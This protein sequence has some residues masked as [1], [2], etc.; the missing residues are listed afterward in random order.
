MQPKPI[1]D[2]VNTAFPLPNVLCV[3]TAAILTGKTVADTG[4]LPVMDFS[5]AVTFSNIGAI[6]IAALAN[7]V[8]FKKPRR[9]ISVLFT[10][11]CFFFI[12]YLFNC[13]LYVCKNT[14]L[15]LS[16]R[17]QYHGIKDQFYRSTYNICENGNIVYD[18]DTFCLAFIRYFCR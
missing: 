10:L 14:V 7:T 2:T 3:R 13:Q 4:D 1:A 5:A 9:P 17:Y 15:N 6:Q 12:S 18:S 16:A 11:S 8:R